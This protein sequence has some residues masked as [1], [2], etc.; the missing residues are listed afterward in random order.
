MKRQL[1]LV[2]LVSAGVLGPAPEALAQRRAGYRA[3]GVAVGPGGG[4]AAWRSAGV[5]RPGLFPAAAW[6]GRGTAVAPGG[7]M[8]QYGAAGGA[9]S[10]PL[11]GMQAGWARGARVTTPSG[12]TYGRASW[13]SVTVG[14][15]GRV[16][17]G[18]SATAVSGP[19]GAAAGVRRGGAVFRP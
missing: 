18:W 19:F 11:G 8:V 9:V 14:P 10:G 5:A 7:S 4:V 17:S 3:G 12:Q 13:G 1:V 15:G 16:T 2:A 6:A